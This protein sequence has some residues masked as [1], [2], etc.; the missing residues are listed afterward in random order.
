MGLVI[1][2]L[3]IV[4]IEIIGLMGQNKKSEAHYSHQKYTVKHQ[5]KGI[6]GKIKDRY[7]QQTHYRKAY[8][9]FGHIKEQQHQLNQEENGTMRTESGLF[10][11]DRH[12]FIPH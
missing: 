1:K 7:E 4:Y 3:P 5:T 12:Y 9:D 8:I 2:I 11:H 6:L 10:Q